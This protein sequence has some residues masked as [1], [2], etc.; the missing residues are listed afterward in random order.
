MHIH[1]HGCCLKIQ[2]KGR[3]LVLHL[4]LVIFLQALLDWTEFTELDL[5]STSSEGFMA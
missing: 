3:R 2:H 5:L 4:V 1:A